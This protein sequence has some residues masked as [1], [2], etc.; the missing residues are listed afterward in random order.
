MENNNIDLAKLNINFGFEETAYMI[1]KSEYDK[2]MEQA[3]WLTREDVESLGLK[4]IKTHGGL[5]E[6]YFHFNDDEH[7]MDYDYDEKYLRIAFGTECESGD[8]TRFSGWINTKD[9]FRFIL[10]KLRLLDYGK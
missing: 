5:N 7:Y 3:N 1:N 2:Y 9:E 10:S 4:Y 8:V 6:D